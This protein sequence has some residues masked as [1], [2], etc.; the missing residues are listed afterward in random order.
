MTPDQA[1]A[2]INAQ[3]ALFRCEVEGM[4]AENQ[5][6]VSCDGSI[7]Y[8]EEAFSA[9]AASWSNIIGANAVTLLF[10]EANQS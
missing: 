4:I 3:T 9:C 7:A 10:N 8:G 1:A 6:R 5:H 2:Y